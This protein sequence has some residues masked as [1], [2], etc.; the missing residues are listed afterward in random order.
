[1]VAG[2]IYEEYPDIEDGDDKE[3][4]CDRTDELFFDAV[5]VEAAD[6]ERLL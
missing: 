5:R 3:D 2:L 1:M 4:W 6:Q